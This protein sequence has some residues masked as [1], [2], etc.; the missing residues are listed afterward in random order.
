[1]KLVFRFLSKLWQA[2]EGH[3]ENQVAALRNSGRILRKDHMVTARYVNVVM[4]RICDMVVT[5]FRKIL[6]VL[7]VPRLLQQKE[8]GPVATTVG[9]T[10]PTEGRLSGGIK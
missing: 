6:D 4:S 1:M 3:C 8:R 9:L 2:L 7:I 10:L 5:K